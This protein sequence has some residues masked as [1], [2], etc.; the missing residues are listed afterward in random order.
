MLAGEVYIFGWYPFG[1]DFLSVHYRLAVD[2]V[3]QLDRDVQPP[4]R[5]EAGVAQGESGGRR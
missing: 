4:E 5:Y 3:G 2:D 1:W